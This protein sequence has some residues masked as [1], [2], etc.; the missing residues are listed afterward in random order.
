M[1][2]YRD[3]L[4]SLSWL[5]LARNLRKQGTS[6]YTLVAACAVDG[7]VIPLPVGGW[8]QEAETAPAGERA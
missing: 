7:Q 2:D 4:R 6:Y 3:I 5:R 8:T 1:P